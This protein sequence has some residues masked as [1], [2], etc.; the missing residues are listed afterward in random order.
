MV[1]RFQALTGLRAVAAI[2]VFLYHNRKAWFG[3]LPEW[4]LQGLNEFH[5]GVSVFFVLSGFL[6]AYTYGE[7]PAA[8][9][10]AYRTYLLV[11][12]ARIFPVY[13]LLLSAKYI[14]LGFPGTTETIATYTLTQGLFD[15]FSL[16]GIPQS[17]SLTTELCFYLLA[18]FLFLWSLKSIARTLVLLCLAFVACIGLGW[19]LQVFKLNPHDFLYGTVFVLRTVFFGRF[20]E[21]YCGILLA[22]QL[23]NKISL[24]CFQWRHQTFMGDVGILLVLVLI[25][26]FQTSIWTHGIETWPGLLIRNLVFPIAVVFFI[27]GLIKEKTWVQWLLGNRV[28]V[29]LGNASFI[30]YLVHLNYINNQLWKWHHFPDRNFTLL[31]IISIIAYLLVEKP[32]YNFLKKRVR[33]T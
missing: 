21:F 9:K 24:R 26:L 8:G 33:K 13:L 11:R 25:S 31:W 32:I 16:S 4:L 20:V 1:N 27:N 28:A 3:W 22:L 18:P 5:T 6:V 12:L 10:N 23:R 17:W 29:L 30:F 7:K 14:H 15:K 19:A 2:M